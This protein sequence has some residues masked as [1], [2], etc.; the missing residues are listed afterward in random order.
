MINSIRAQR[1]RKIRWVPKKGRFTERWFLY[2]DYAIL[3]NNI[4][5]KK[6]FKLSILL[7][8]NLKILYR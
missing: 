8:Y 7:I 3:T 2:N 6:Y 5:L 4:T 1:T